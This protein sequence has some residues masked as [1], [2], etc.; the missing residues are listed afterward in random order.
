MDVLIVAVATAIGAQQHGALDLHERYVAAAAALWEE[1]ARQRAGRAGD[2]VHAGV[3]RHL[4]LAG[5]VG[6]IAPTHL[7]FIDHQD[8]AKAGVAE[9]ELATVAQHAVLGAELFATAPHH[10]V[11]VAGEALLAGAA[12]HAG[13]LQFGARGDNVRL[14][15][16]QLRA[17]AL[18]A[19]G[20]PSVAQECLRPSLGR[21]E[22]A[23]RASTARANSTR[24]QARAPRPQ[25]TRRPSQLAPRGCV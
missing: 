18:R 21:R 10:A 22:R 5:H 13:P 8:G 25:S 12:E 23:A 20:L 1:R 16:A 15:Y 7:A 11:V 2:A 24:C 3:A 4:V 6:E 19:R 17:K 14:D 9:E